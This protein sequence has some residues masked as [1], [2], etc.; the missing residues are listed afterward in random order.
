MDITDSCCWSR[1]SADVWLDGRPISTFCEPTD[2]ARGWSATLARTG[3]AAGTRRHGKIVQRVRENLGFERRYA[4]RGLAGQSLLLVR[5][6]FGDALEF[7]YLAQHRSGELS[8]AQQETQA[9]GI[10]F[11]FDRQ[12]ANRAA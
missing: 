5:I 9:Q 8:P 3:S 1:T 11:A 7:A 10:G 2:A 6:E 4:H 12:F